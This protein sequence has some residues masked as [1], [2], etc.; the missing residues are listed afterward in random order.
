MLIFLAGTLTTFTIAMLAVTIGYKVL[1][2]PFA[3]LTGMVAGLFTQPSVLGFALE[4]ARNDLPN[5]G[6]SAVF[7]TATILKVIL[8]QILIT[9]FM[10]S[11]A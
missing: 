5:V 9:P 11:L 8:A 7:P 1:K 3:I 4:Q 2:I 10:L 6:Y